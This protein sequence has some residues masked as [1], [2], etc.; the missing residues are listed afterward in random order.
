MAIVMGGVR[1]CF[2]ETARYIIDIKRLK[3]NVD[4]KTRLVAKCGCH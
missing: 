4:A 3:S 1:I 2:T